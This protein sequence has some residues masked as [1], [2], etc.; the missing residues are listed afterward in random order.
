MNDTNFLN[1]ILYMQAI[2]T[3][4]SQ[5]RMQFNINNMNPVE[6]KLIEY[7]RYEN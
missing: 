3:I 4:A 2:F 6:T 1:T 7:Q 5:G